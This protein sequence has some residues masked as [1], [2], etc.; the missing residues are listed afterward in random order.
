MKLGFYYHVP[1]HEKNRR[2]LCIPAYLGVF[3]DE[4]AKNVDEL[5][6]FA[7]EDTYSTNINNYYILKSKNIVWINLGKKK[8]FIHRFI[9]GKSLLKKYKIEASLCDIIL[10]RAPSPLAP[11]FYSSFK[12]ITK[13]SFLVVGDYVIG[14]NFLKI[15]FFKKMLSWIFIKVNEKQQNDAIKRCLTFVNSKLL[16]QKYKDKSLELVEVKTTTIMEKDFFYRKDTCDKPTIQLLYTGRLDMSKGFYELLSACK[17][18]SDDNLDFKLNI[19]GWEENILSPVEHYINSKSEELG[20]KGNIVLHGKKEAGLELNKMYRMA[21]IYILP[22][23]H[24]GFPRTIWEAMANSIPV[25]STNVG[26]IPFF[27]NNNEHAIL[28]ESKQTIELYE[29]INRMLNNPKLRRLVIKNAFNY[30]QNI[31]LEKQTPKIIEKLNSI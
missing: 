29:A 26:S 19:V 24:E 17:L 4:I 27:L 6:L 16:F 13:I 14:Q 8:S 21:D 20:I 10:V 5:R 18:L 25:I 1:I 7:H 28:I 31:T 3:I 12:S 23:Y 11:Y 30:V 15:N 2:D 22:S 9:M